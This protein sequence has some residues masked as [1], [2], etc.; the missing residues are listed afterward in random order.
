MAGAIATRSSR[1]DRTICLPISESVFRRVV[2]DPA[3]FRQVI[4]DCFK[5]MPELFPANFAD[6]YQLK[7]H[8]Q[9]NK[10]KVSIRRVLTR[11]GAAYSLRPSYLMP[12]M[13]GR[14]DDV[15]GPLFLRKFGL[16]FWALARFL[17][18]DPMSWYRLESS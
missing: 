1:G 14:T 11:D 18:R 16:P 3:Q 10:Q 9:S 2:H 8:R 5:R 13:A 4:G 6:G 17:G 12:S 15:E 7:D